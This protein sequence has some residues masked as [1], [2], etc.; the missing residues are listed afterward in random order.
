M[1]FFELISKIFDF[2]VHE[3]QSFIQKLMLVIPVLQL[4]HHADV[5]GGQLLDLLLLLVMLSSIS[6]VSHS[7]VML[8]SVHLFHRPAFVL[9]VSPK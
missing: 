1:L 5:L 8:E 4:S 9:L 6:L 2:Q 7:Q 3:F